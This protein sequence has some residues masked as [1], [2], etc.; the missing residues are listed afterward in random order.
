MTVERVERRLAA[1]FAADVEGYSRLM[2]ADEVS[3][4]RNLTQRRAILD[5]LIASFRGRIVNTG[6]D[7]VLAEFGSAVDAVQCA[8]EGQAA[9]GAANVGLS[10]N[11][12]MNFRIGI[13]VGD[14]MVKAGDLFGDSVN[15][16]ARL[17]T[18]ATAGG[19]C[20]SGITHDQVR[21]ILPFVFTDLGLQQVKNIDEPVRAFAVCAKG[22][23]VITDDTTASVTLALPD[24]PSIAVLPF[25]NMSGDPEQEYFADG[26]VEDIITALSRFKS[27]FVIARNSSFTYKGKAVDIKQVARDLG[28][29]YVLEGSVRKS[30]NRIRITGQLID[31]ASGAHLWADRYD[32]ALD[33][34]FKLQDQIAASVV[35]AIVPSLAQ[36]EIERAK[37]KPINSLDAY[38]YYLR[39]LAAHWQYTKSDNEK[40]IALFERSAALDPQF[41]PAQSAL[42]ATLSSRWGWEWSANPADDAA[43]SISCA[44]IAL[45]LGRH[46]PLVLAQSAT[47]LVICG[48]EVELADGFFEDAIRLNPNE[49][50]GWMWGGLAK[51]LLGKHQHAIE[52]L[53]RALRVS[54]LDPRV[55]FAQDILGLAH[56]FL[57]NYE[58]G[59]S[60]AVAASLHHSNYAPALRTAMAC[61]ALLGK[62]EDARRLWGLVALLSPSDRVSTQ[63]QRTKYRREEDRVKLDEAY[64][65]AGMP[66]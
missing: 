38:D 21:K 31:A 4:L 42:S 5:G 30:A 47:S 54:P 17:Q 8:V 18:I 9:L 20:V 27:L 63:K 16:A 32:G 6:G 57:G 14:V 40:A 29:R 37:R 39:G 45:R 13:H 35:G 49:L 60:C 26:M 48:D 50:N 24:K 15:I 51:V 61:N 3:T 33:D 1:I 44:N 56:F 7:S 46:D 64:R 34:V 52:Y 19:V 11:L 25:Q 66:E 36:A 43:R 22:D 65:S 12:H 55:F 41:A 23:F 28:V 10:P 53:Q 2:G 62:I 58:E 59:L